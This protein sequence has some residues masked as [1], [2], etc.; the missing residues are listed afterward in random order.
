MIKRCKMDV[1]IS[2]II[3]VYNVEDYLRQCVDSIIS[4][5]FKNKEI[6]LVNDGSKDNSPK[7]CD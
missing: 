1:S 3:P 4:Q 5:D 2:I 6:I 7:I